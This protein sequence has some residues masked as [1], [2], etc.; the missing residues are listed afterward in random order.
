VS[1]VHLSGNGTL[2]KM[3]GK[4]LT[5]ANHVGKSPE[6]EVKETAI[7]EAPMTV[8]VAPISIDIYRFPVVHAAP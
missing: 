7:A 6:V 2:W 8:T 1:G 4:D 3:T 5:A